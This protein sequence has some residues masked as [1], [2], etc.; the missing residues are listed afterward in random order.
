MGFCASGGYEYLSAMLNETL[1][2]IF[3]GYSLRRVPSEV[4]VCREYVE[5]AVTDS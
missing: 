4:E 5:G 2:K 1:V 3:S